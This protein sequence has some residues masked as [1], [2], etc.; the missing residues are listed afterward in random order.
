MTASTRRAWQELQARKAFS[1]QRRI[2]DLFTADA[3]RF[4]KFSF[5]VED[6]LLDISKQNL[7]SADLQLLLDLAVESDL[8]AAIANLCAGAV[9]NRTENRAAWHT[10]LR[11]PHT[12][13]V[14]IK[15][16]LEKMAAFVRMAH[17][18]GYTD[19]ISVGIGGSDLGPR[20]A[21]EA[22]QPFAQGRLR[23]H[24]LANVD[25]DSVHS[26]LNRLNP[27]TTLCLINSKTFT[28]IE[29]LAVAKLLQEWCENLYAVTANPAQAQAFGITAERIFEFWD[30]VGGRYSIWSAVG[31]PIALQVGMDNFLQMLAGAHALDQHF[32]HT[33]FAHNLPVLMGLVGIWNVN[34]Q[35]H[36]S[37]CVQP[38]CNGLRLLPEYLQQL[39]M[40][41]NGKNCTSDNQG[42][43]YHTAPIIWG[44]VG[45]NSQHAFMQMLHQ[46][47]QV[48]PVDFLLPRRS[49]GN[50][51]GLH[52]I[53]IA[54][55]LGQS[56][57]LMQG[58][59]AEHLY[60]ACDGNKP[61]STIIFEQ[62]T[63]Y[64]LGMLLA[65]YEHKI[66]VQ[67]TIWGIES[68]DQWGVQLGKTLINRLLPVCAGEPS[69][70]LDGS[71]AGLLQN[72]LRA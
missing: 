62:L 24:F 45:C 70:D 40:E 18:G 5:A 36:S 56:Q 58:V 66:F 35:Q 71:T 28:T 60:K 48:V 46:G 17:A 63:P 25:A 4:A 14:A 11:N 72:V 54:S 9:V 7:D 20:L 68:F 6:V 29:T 65:L 33:D 22:L 57:A 30:W 3:E 31:L 16:S 64:A 26:L 39:D 19:V 1:A 61:S 67:G 47:T 23:M 53:L 37:L 10:E 21:C 52:K 41:S 12:K 2:T 13:V 8:S 51:L 55:C 43:S 15:A 42:V 44:G 69:T 50:D 49:V 27:Q 59:G 32:I 38:Y 34:F